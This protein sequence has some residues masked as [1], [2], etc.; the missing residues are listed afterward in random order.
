MNNIQKNN[1]P[2]AQSQ[3]NIV[4]NSENIQEMIIAQQ[5]YFSGPLPSPEILEQYKKIGVLDNILTIAMDSN[6]RQNKKV[7]I[8]ASENR[9]KELLNIAK[10]RKINVNTIVEAVT[11]IIMAV[12]IFLIVLSCWGTMLYGFIVKNYPTSIILAVLNAVT[13]LIAFL[14]KRK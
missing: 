9:Q 7:E 10:A 3:N 6:N 5:H 2:I 1:N 4:P 14:Q 8:L 13:V 12:I 11:Q